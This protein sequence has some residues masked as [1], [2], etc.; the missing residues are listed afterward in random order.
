ML[1]MFTVITAETK[2]GKD[3]KTKKSGVNTLFLS[4]FFN[5]AINLA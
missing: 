3:E 4:P 5:V 1:V 2:L